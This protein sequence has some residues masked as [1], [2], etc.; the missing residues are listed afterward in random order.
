MRIF[1]G[2]TTSPDLAEIFFMTHMLTRDLF[3]VVNLLVLVI[4][5]SITSQFSFQYSEIN[6]SSYQLI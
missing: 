6:I 3:V 4:A 2:S 5:L 1:T